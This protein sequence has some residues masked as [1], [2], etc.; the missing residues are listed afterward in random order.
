MQYHR[1]VDGVQIVWV[2][3]W[4][5]AHSEGQKREGWQRL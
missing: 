2:R 4:R 3:A 5:E 1:A